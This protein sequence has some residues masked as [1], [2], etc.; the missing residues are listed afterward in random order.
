MSP[1]VDAEQALRSS[2]AQLAAEANALARLNEASSRLWRIRNLREGLD[3]MLTAT[4][5]LLGADMGNV[6][7][8][9]AQKGVLLIAAQRGFKLDFLDFFREVSTEDDSACGRALRSGERIVI[10][11]VENDPPYAPL[12]SVARAAG[13]RGVLSTPLIARDGTPLGM[14]S[15]HFRSVHRPSEQDLRR[16]DLYVR[17]AADFIERCRTDEEL[18]Q[19]EARRRAMVESALDGIITIDQQGRIVEFN[20]AAERLFGYPREDAVGREMAE[21]IVPPHLRDKHRRGLVHYLQTGVASVL[22]RRLEMTAMRRDGTNF[23]VELSITRVSIA[24]RPFFTGYVRDITER[25]CAEEQQA[26]FINELNHRVKNTLA[27]I[28]SIAAQTL[29]E[30]PEPVAFK[31]A[32][33]ARLAA[34]ASA[35]TL[36]T[37]GLWHGA[38]LYDIVSVTLAPFCVDGRQEAMRIKGQSI[39]IKP[40]IAVTLTLVL[41]ELA[42]NAAK[43]GAL[44]TPGGHVSVEWTDKVGTPGQPDNIEF[45]WKEEGGP[46]VQ[47]PKKR[48]FGSRLIAA[49]TDQLGGDV[50]VKYKPQGVE[51]W[52]RLPLP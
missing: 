51:A 22:D 47:P 26:L 45:S 35:H 41:H 25:K 43:H 19:R 18:Y 4:I 31:A 7:I 33:S 20:A 28:Q 36:L 29:R 3:E 27:I 10:E 17:Q 6:Q 52:F 48:G 46:A 24:D 32:F 37:R 11:D 14:L 5:E 30:T 2:Q 49:S 1:A 34:L 9:N 39:L 38:S 16:L 42:T 23:P 21:L 50:E 8:L 13:Y 44:T 15:T 40:N 12:L